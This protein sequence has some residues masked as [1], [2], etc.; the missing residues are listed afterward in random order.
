MSMA[1]GVEVRVPFLDADVV[2][3][4]ARLPV[5]VKQ[6]GRTGKWVLKK[7]MEPHLPREVIH[8]PKTGF[9]APLRRWLR[10]DLNG[11]VAEL[12]SPETLRRRG[13]FDPEAVGRLLAQDRAGRMDG[14]Y[15]IFGLMAIE[16]WCRGFL[17]ETGSYCFNGQGKPVAGAFATIRQEGSRGN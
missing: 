17:D 9:G 4:A 10:H 15:T 1:A 2:G 5:R 13:L 3:L 6:R 8:R 16:L 14:T 11:L 7:A 12:L